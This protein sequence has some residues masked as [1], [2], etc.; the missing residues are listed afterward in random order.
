MQGFFVMVVNGFGALF[1]SFTSGLL[2]DSFFTTNTTKDWS[3]IWLF[4]AVLLF[5]IVVLY[6]LLLWNKK[7]EK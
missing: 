6:F 4:F 2:I 5:L 3:A 1:G 7:H